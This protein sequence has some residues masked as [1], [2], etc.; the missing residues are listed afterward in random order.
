LSG[1]AVRIG[2]DVIDGSAIGRLDRLR[3]SLT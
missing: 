1:L 2:D 3:R